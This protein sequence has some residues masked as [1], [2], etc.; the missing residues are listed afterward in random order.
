MDVQ[1]QFDRE[2]SVRL[3]GP[4]AA[5]LDVVVVF[6]GQP[7]CVGGRFDVSGDLA[8]L[9]RRL[10]AAGDGQWLAQLRDS[11]GHVFDERWFDRSLAEA[12]FGPA[13]VADGL[14]RV[15]ALN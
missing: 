2:E 4:K 6:A 9:W 15:R 1:G 5:S 7:F 10:P 14:G 8:R 3:R 11:E 13:F 12:L